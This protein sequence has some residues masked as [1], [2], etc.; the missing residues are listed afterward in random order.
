MAYCAVAVMV[1]RTAHWGEN[2]VRRE[3]TVTWLVRVRRVS[4]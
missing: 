3:R 4:S 1:A 2:R